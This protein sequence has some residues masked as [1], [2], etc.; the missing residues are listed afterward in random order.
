MLFLT[1][2]QQVMLPLRLA[3]LSL[4]GE[5]R[6]FRSL[7]GNINLDL[8]RFP[9]HVHKQSLWKIL[10][11][12]GD[13]V[14]EALITQCLESSRRQSSVRIQALIHRAVTFALRGRFLEICFRRSHGREG[15]RL[16]LRFKV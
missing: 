13:L 16:R 11:Q 6:C 2:L 12:I 15:L 3:P 10:V 1:C 4:G 5:F 14:C 8:R 9:E 7:C